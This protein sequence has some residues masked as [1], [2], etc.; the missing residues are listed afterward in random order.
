M[1]ENFGAIA[2]L[3]GTFNSLSRDH[4]FHLELRQ[5]G[6][7]LHKPLST[8]SLGITEPDSGIFRLSAAFCRGAPSHK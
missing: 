7:L 4:G 6:Q 2:D 3:V 1:K 8:P 5:L